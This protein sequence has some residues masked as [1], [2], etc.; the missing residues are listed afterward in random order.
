MHPIIMPEG[1]LDGFDGAR[2]GGDQLFE[3]A[4][5]FLRRQFE[6]VRQPI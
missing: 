4:G 3:Q 6:M 2:F 1:K 5:F